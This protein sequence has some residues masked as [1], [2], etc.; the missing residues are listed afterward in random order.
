VWAKAGRLAGVERLSRMATLFTW[1]NPALANSG[2]D[3]AGRDALASK[4]LRQVTP[5]IGS[6]LSG[7][8]ML[9]H[10]SAPSRCVAHETERTSV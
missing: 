10:A 8:V 6:G 5:S 1:P 3:A 2:A 9:H 4:S 7:V